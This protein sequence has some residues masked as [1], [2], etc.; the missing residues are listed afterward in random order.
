MKAII[1]DLYHPEKGEIELGYY[2]AVLNLGNEIVELKAK[3][4]H[5]FDVFETVDNSIKETNMKKIENITKAVHKEDNNLTVIWEVE[6]ENN[7]VDFQEIIK[8]FEML[9]KI[10]PNMNIEIIHKGENPIWLTRVNG[11]ILADLNG[12]IEEIKIN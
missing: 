10:N 8:R 2:G 3:I 9:N 4:N 1:A 11:L 6:S 12:K 7:K 5:I